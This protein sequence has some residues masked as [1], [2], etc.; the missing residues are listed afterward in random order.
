MLL[1]E[2]VDLAEFHAYDFGFEE[3]VELTVVAIDIDGVLYGVVGILRLCSGREHRADE[4]YG[5]C[6]AALAA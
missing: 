1:S 3:T 4:Q 6:Q 2:R 5:E